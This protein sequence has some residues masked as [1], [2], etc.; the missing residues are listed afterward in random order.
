LSG[1]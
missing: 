1:E